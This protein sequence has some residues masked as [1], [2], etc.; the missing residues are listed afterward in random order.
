MNVDAYIEAQ[1]AIVALKAAI[2]TV[3][4]GSNSEG[5]RNA[6]IGRQLGIY[7]GHVG[8]EGHIPRTILAQ[9]QTE[10]VVRQDPASKRWYL[11]EREKPGDE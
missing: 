4:S 3:I 5:V 7:G 9:L 1:R 10:G 2:L 11:C 6:E 8:H